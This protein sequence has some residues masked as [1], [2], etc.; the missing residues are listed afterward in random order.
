VFRIPD[1]LV[2]LWLGITDLAQN[3][4]SEK[5]S[6]SATTVLGSRLRE[7]LIRTKK[8]FQA[9]RIEGK[10]TFWLIFRRKSDLMVDL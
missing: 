10:V 5:N 6:F 8:S 4:G 3:I 2:W 7:I 9:W 1:T